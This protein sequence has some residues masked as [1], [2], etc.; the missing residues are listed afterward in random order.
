MIP[1]RLTLILLL[2][3]TILSGNLHAQTITI[4]GSESERVIAELNSNGS[5]RRLSL[6]YSDGWQEVKFRTDEYSG[7]GFGKLVPLTQKSSGIPVFYGETE[8]ISYQMT[9]SVSA[10]ALQLKVTLRNNSGQTFAPD[11]LPLILGIDAFMDKYPQWNTLYFPTFLRCEPSHFW[12]YFMTPLGKILGITCK[13]PVGSYTIAYRNEMYDHYIN[14]ASLD[15]LQKPPVPE[16]HPA[17]KPLAAGEERTWTIKIMAIAKL[18]QVKPILARNADAPMLDLYS[19]TLEPNQAAEFSIVSPVPVAV[20]VTTPA[21]KVIPLSN[22]SISGSGKYQ[23]QYTNTGE[24]GYYDVHIN[25]ENGKTAIGRFYVRPKWSWYLQGARQEALR[26][27]P[28][29]DFNG[30]ADGYSCETY[31]GL[32]GF[33]LAAKHFPDPAIDVKGDKILEKILSRLFKEENG[34]YMSGNRERIQNGSFM[35]SVLVDKYQATGDMNTLEMAEKFAVYLLSR[36][37]PDGYYGGYGM[38]PYTSVL[39]VAKAIVELMEVEKPLGL[40]DPKWKELYDKHYQSV[41]RSID[42]L[43]LKKLDVKTEG[44]GTF[45]DGSVSCSATQIA[46]F[47]LMQDDPKERQRYADAALGFLNAHSCLT[48]LLSPDT[49]SNGSTIRWWEAWGDNKVDGQMTT[50]PHGWSGWRLYAVYYEYLLTGREDLLQGVMNALGSCAQLMDWPSGRLRQAY[51]IDPH[52]QAFKRLPD[53]KDP[54]GKA[55]P[56]VYGEE[57]LETIGDWYGKCTIGD[58]YLDRVEWG[59][60]G[61]QIPYEIFKAMEE[62]ALTAAYVIEREDGT[63]KTY[64]C[65]AEKIGGSLIITPAEGL[66]SK[67]HV[68]TKNPLKCQVRFAGRKPVNS[69]VH[70]MQWIDIQGSRL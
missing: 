22:L 24:Y 38:N 28:R 63:I 7:P 62:F 10:G 9:Y 17:Y 1:L 67:V 8:G 20:T 27:T 5:I 23:G 45:E 21:G 11:R 32:L 35:L 16:H 59:W 49:R 29:A 2:T 18:D 47:A 57:Y 53:P 60:T 50:S 25:A 15:L 48:R 68:N 14:T 33:W 51:V 64:N 44:G 36:Q 65:S 43:V 52:L 40:K 61:D 41:K 58:S 31:Y 55:V 37:H 42:D 4:V 39:Y 46:M 56:Y 13:D 6:R 54:Y 3:G 70:G 69:T 66:V 34:M 19:Y 12:G 30:D 26:L